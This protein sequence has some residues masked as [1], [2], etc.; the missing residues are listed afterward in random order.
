MTTPHPATADLLVADRIAGL[1]R[2]SASIRLARFAEL[3]RAGV[4]AR[5]DEDATEAEHADDVG[6]EEVG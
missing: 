2:D 6:R 1:D 4:P 3:D 5:S